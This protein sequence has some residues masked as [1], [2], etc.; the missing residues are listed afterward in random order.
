MRREKWTRTGRAKHESGET[1]CVANSFSRTRAKTEIFVSELR[2]DA[3][4]E[5]QVCMYLPMT[6]MIRILAA[7]RSDSHSDIKFFHYLSFR[8]FY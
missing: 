6:H 2:V 3:D 4:N 7:S 1:E 5:L 8:Y